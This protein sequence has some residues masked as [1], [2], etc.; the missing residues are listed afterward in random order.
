[1]TNRPQMNFPAFY[2]A[3]KKL[4]ESGY[5]V[6]SPAELD[7][8]HD[9]G[10]ALSSPDGTPNHPTKTWGD[11]LA[12][13]VKMIADGGIKGIIFLPDWETSRGA[14][15]EASLGLLQPDFVFFQYSNGHVHMLSR[16]AVAWSIFDATNRG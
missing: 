11:F 14:R 10:I 15:L 6:V 8:T 16:R 13:D 9:A 7:D 5:D 4:R 1:M 2:A 12:R 3:A